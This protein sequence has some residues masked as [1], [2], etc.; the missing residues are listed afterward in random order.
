MNPVTHQQT[1]F[2]PYTPNFETPNLPVT[3]PTPPKKGR[4]FSLTESIFAWLCLI[5]G[6]LFCRVYPISDSPFGGLLFTLILFISS[7]VAAKVMRK[8]ISP[9]P[10][11]AAFSAIVIS[12]SLIFTSSDFIHFFSY[13][14]SLVILCYFIYS[15]NGNSVKRGLSDLIVADFIKALFIMPFC[16]FGY[17]FKAM[18]IGKTNG[19]KKVFLKILIG[20]GIAIIPTLIVFGLLSYDSD[21]TDLL[22]IIFDFNFEDIWSHIGSVILG[23]PIGLYIFGLFISSVDNKCKNVLSEEISAKLIKNIKIAPIAT[24]I[25][26]VVPIL[27]LYIVF[28]VS[29]WKY[30]ISGFTGVLP[31]NFSYAVYAREGFFQLCTVAVIN[32]V[33]ITAVIL[34]IKK[35]TIASN[36]TLKTT[37]IVFSLATLI[38]ISTA[39][40]KMVMYIDTYGLTQKRVYATWLMILIALIFILIT[41]KQ[42]VRKFKVVAISL[43]VCVSMF[44]LLA[45]PNVDAIIAKYNVGRYLDGSLETVDIEA[46][47]ELGSSA[48][49]SLAELNEYLK[50][51]DR[52]IEEGSLYYDVTRYLNCIA[53]DIEEKDK[54]IFA[55]TIPDALAEKALKDIGYL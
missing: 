49:P 18:F 37:V 21:F 10:L 51:A 45:L 26:A 20:A 6:Y 42:F 41:L 39:I 13:S 11:L 31:E 33:L 25:A 54:D 9:K 36:I 53:D 2:N 29:Q 14:Y 16:S 55:F 4:G 8:K 38:L 32:L 40:A 15:V 48:V 5:F 30:Y 12:A 19:G 23:V 17:M 1:N 28:F 35:G 44:A 50:E 47:Q 52:S 43:I 34:F 7:F 24:I 27:F 3:T 22:D 46:M